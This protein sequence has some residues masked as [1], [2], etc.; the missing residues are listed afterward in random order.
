M[1]RKG[2]R[3]AQMNDTQTPLE[4]A[5]SGRNRGT[6][7]M[8]A[9]AIRHDQARLAYQ[10]VM[11]ARP[12]HGV[13]FYEGLIRVP[14]ETGRIIPAADFMPVVEDT[15][16][17]REIDCAALASGL[18]ALA[19]APDLRLSV[20]MSARSIGFRKW[21]RILDRGL[22]RDPDIGARL[23]LEI[24][25][26]SMMLMPEV[27]A[28]FMVRMQSH[29]IS[30]ALDDFGAGSTALRFLRDVYFDAIKIDGQFIRNLPDAPANQVLVSAMVAVA[31]QFDMFVV[32]ESVETL[33]EA[34]LLGRI[35]VD[36]LQ[37]YLY[38]APS[39]R[40]PWLP[41]KPARQRA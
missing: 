9:G 18:R 25:E 19:A 37:G 6:L 17:G 22:N 31:R 32:A 8:V 16:L 5:V 7:D 40:P 26:S 36:C 15:E 4:I 38:G 29:G 23:I 24:T 2:R 20:N 35:G 12:P 27:V 10:P 21:Q 13:A 14:D 28:D 30:F 3:A 41:E 34:E 39:L 11:Q 1:T 33:P